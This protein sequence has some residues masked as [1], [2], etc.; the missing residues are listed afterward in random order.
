MKNTYII[1]EINFE[2][3]RKTMKELEVLKMRK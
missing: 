3:K 2:L 1:V